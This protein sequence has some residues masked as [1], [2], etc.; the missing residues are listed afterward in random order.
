M[1]VTELLDEYRGEVAI[2]IV[3][4]VLLA[5]GVRLRD[6]FL[7]F[8]REETT[9]RGIQLIFD[10]VV[11]GFRVSS[12]SYQAR[13]GV[14]PDMTT[15]R[16]FL[17]GGLPIRALCGRTELFENARPDVDVPEAERVLA[18]GGT[19]TANPMMAAA[20]LASLS[21]VEAD[22]VYEHTESLAEHV[23]RGLERVYEDLGIDARVLG[24][25]SMFLSH[26][27]PE[28]PLTDVE[29]V[30]TATNRDALVEFHRLLH[31][32]GYYF[33]PGHVGS[34]SYQTSEEQLDGF[35]KAAES[36]ARDLLEEGV[37]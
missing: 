7:E 28:R 29:A 37:L 20:G 2:V 14:T 16:K 15:L 34:V 4:P 18:G 25:S 32:D 22:P 31:D 6:E 33:L 26:F 5:G 3:D 27:Q 35:L 8:L 21:V 13:V 30:E 36:V 24:V 12:G 17:G 1:A 23:R 11:T 19:F 9:E 10:E